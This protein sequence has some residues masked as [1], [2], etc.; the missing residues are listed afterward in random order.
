MSNGE[1]AD[2]ETVVTTIEINKKLFL[3]FKAFCVLKELKIS[4]E[5]ESLIR[6]RVEELAKKTTLPS[7]SESQQD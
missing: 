7:T 3:D 6:R 2:S 1:S 4:E 5:I